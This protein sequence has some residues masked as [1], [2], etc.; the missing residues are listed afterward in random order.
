VT[1][2]TVQFQWITVVVL[3]L[4]ALT[5]SQPQPAPP[6]DTGIENIDLGIKLAS[7]PEG[8]AEAI[9][10]GSDLELRPT[11][12]SV[13][14]VLWFAVGPEQRGVNLVAAVHD[15]Q[16]HIESL[17]EGTY[18]G[19]QELQGDFGVAFYSRGRFSDSDATVEETVLFRIHPSGNRLLEIH[20]RYPAG[21]DSAARVEQLIGVLAEL[22]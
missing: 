7:V 15:H 1:T 16:A 4:T 8:L 21:D 3:A 12:E 14:G 19:A 11:D 5:C 13:G 17:P 9:N 10:Q 22:E 2:A 20:Y 6:P 18:K